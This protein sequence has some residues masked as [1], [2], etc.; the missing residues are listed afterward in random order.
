VVRQH[1]HHHHGRHIDRA[2]SWLGLVRASWQNTLNEAHVENNALAFKNDFFPYGF[3]IFSG[4]I[5][6]FSLGF[7][8][9]GNHRDWQAREKALDARRAR[10][11]ENAA[12]ERSDRT[13][14]EME[15]LCSAFAP[16]QPAIAPSFRYSPR[17]EP[18]L[19]Q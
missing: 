18:S 8:A 5:F 16:H 9:G 3:M 19:A 6:C 12:V 1:C 15:D 4:L 2:L 17:D 7:L 10:C 14:R 11:E 13:T